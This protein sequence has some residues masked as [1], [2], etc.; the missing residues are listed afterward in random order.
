M[1]GIASFPIFPISKEKLPIGKLLIAKEE[2]A[3]VWNYYFS[4]LDEFVARELVD[5]K[6]VGAFKEIY[7][8]PD[9]FCC[10]FVVDSVGICFTFIPYPNR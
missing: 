10:L 5:S 9:E 3:L 7:K 1:R 4:F 2:L 8:D 6:K